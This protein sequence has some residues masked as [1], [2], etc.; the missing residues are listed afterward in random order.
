M[1]RISTTGRRPAMAAPTPSPT[2]P[3]SLSGVSMTRPGPN[4]GEQALGDLVGA[5]ALPDPLADAEHGRVAFHL[6][7][8]SRPEGFAVLHLGHV[9]SFP[10]RLAGVRRGSA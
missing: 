5:A 3:A 4:S 9:A 2:K 6:F 8:K 1:N 7:V 10:G